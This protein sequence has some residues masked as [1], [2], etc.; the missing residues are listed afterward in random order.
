[1]G[2]TKKPPAGRNQR[3]GKAAPGRSLAD[4]GRRRR[5]PWYVI[6]LL[7][8]L[9]FFGG[10]S[11]WNQWMDARTAE[12]YPPQGVIIPDLPMDYGDGGEDAAP[13]SARPGAAGEEEGVPEA[14]EASIHVMVRGQRTREN[15]PSVLMLGGW[16][17]VSPA[18]DYQPLYR[19]L[20]DR[21]RVIIVEKPGY[22]WSGR[23]FSERTLDNMVEDIIYA[24]GGLEESGP[25]V[26]V[27]EGTAG[28]E[29]I[30]MAETHPSMVAGIV[31]INA[32]PP[33]V[34]AYRVSR[35]LD[36][37]K[38]YTYPA[39]R[40]TGVFRAIAAFAPEL[41]SGGRPEA[42][43]EAYAVMFCH[44]VM[45]AA[46]R[47]EARM[48][49]RNARSCLADAAGLKVPA[50]S[51]IDRAGYEANP[52]I[53]RVWSDFNRSAAAEVYFCE[54]EPRMPLQHAEIP[55]ISRAILDMAG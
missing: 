16:G 9:G 27:A 26:V 4:A 18:L 53:S 37:L 51:F 6:T 25:F 23:L 43:V 8:C 2:N 5:L 28:L 12:L 40:V 3:G 32:P 50:V 35:P 7:F 31:F 19:T 48:L 42:D 1:M 17:T 22:G 24:L 20:T 47:A 29:A 46:M 34:Y 39:P 52:E 49:S 13:P 45:S 44:N 38:A 36:Y 54:P 41:L 33:A 10:G 15:Q 30:R 11:I 55:A 14:A 21:A